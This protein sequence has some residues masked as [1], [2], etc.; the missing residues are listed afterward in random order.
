MQATS[1][2]NFI[3]VVL[4]LVLSAAKVTAQDTSKEA[5]DPYD[6]FR[7][8]LDV[9]DKILVPEHRKQLEVKIEFMTV[10]LMWGNAV[11]K[12]RGQPLL[13]C[14]PERLAI[15]GTLMID[16]M[17]SD[18]ERSSEM[19]RLSSGDDGRGDAYA[20]ISMQISGSR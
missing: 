8:I 9:Y 6:K 4:L 14:Q 5:R 15:P 7:N 2:R 16:M 3:L 10:A 17:A 18:V 12:E 11:L 13:Y 19:G 20:G 1:M